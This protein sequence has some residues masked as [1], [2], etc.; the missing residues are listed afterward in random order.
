MYNISVCIDVIRKFNNYKTRNGWNVNGRFKLTT[1]HKSFSKGF[2]NWVF[3]ILAH[4]Q[5]IKLKLKHLLFY[6]SKA[7][8]HLNKT[9]A[10]NIIKIF[11]NFEL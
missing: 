5:V 6:K 7:C 8:F 2:K 10:F 3:I 1:L 4:N 9:Q 11:Y